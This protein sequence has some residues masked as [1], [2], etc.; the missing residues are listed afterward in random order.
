MAMLIV[1][2][3]MALVAVAY[4]TLTL[5]GVLHSE[6]TGPQPGPVARGEIKPPKMSDGTATLIGYGVLALSVVELVIA[7]FLLMGRPFARWLAM[8]WCLL[9]ITVLTVSIFYRT[10]IWF[11][12]IANAFIGLNLIKMYFLLMDKRTSRYFAERGGS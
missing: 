10:H 7:F 5:T 8:A 11:A 12:L 6:L 1:A 3:I 4:I 9:E 2:L